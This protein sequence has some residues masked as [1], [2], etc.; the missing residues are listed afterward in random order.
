MA[1]QPEP[2]KK[3]SNQV[4]LD[5][6]AQRLPPDYQV[7]RTLNPQSAIFDPEAPF[8]VVTREGFIPPWSEWDFN[9]WEC[10]TD[11]ERVLQE[12]AQEVRS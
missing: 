7:E 11:K 6:T 12:S 5:M 4:Q 9:E 10:C 3:M 1:M 8:V 2:E